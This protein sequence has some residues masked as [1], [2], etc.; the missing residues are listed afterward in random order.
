M[1]PSVLPTHGYG[2]TGTFPTDG[3]PHK[4]C[5]SPYMYPQP[6]LVDGVIREASGT[7]NERPE[8]TSTAC[9]QWPSSADLTNPPEDYRP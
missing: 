5:L 7:P 3:V 2:G 9:H 1:P 6:I 4:R 8:L